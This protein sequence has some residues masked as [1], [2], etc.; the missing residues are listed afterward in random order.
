MFGKKQFLW[1]FIICVTVSLAGYFSGLFIDFTRDAGKYATISRDIFQNGDFINLTVK[2]HPYIQKPPL[3]FWL[4]A[5]GFYVGGVSNFWFKFPVFLV[6]MFGLYSTYRLGKSLYNRNVGFIASVMLFFSVVYSLYSMD[7]HTDTPLQAF[8]AFA[9][10]QL[11]EFIKTKKERHWILGFIGIGLAMLTKGPIGAVV[12]A[13]AV[14]GHLILKKDFRFLFNFRWFLGILIALIVTSPAL[15]GL[16]RHFGWVGIEFFFWKNNFGRITGDYVQTLNYNPMFYV[17]TMVYL[18]FPWI[19]LFFV[20][21]FLDFKSLIKNKFRADEYFTFFGIW[22]FF[23][24]LSFSKGQLPNYIFI[25]M[26]LIAVL[27]S[28]WVDKAITSSDSIYSIFYKCQNVVTVLI[29]VVILTVA[30]YLF[31]TSKWY[32]WLIFSLAFI[33]SLYVFKSAEH[34]TTALLLP[35]IIA[36]ACLH[37]LINT[38]ALPYMFSFQASPKAARYFNE[39]AQKS[40][41]L[42]SYHYGQYELYFY[43][44]SGATQLKNQNELKDAACKSGNWI[45]T[46]EEGLAEIKGLNC[47]PDTVISYKHVNLDQPAKFILPSKRD[48]ALVPFYLVKF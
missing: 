4:G 17:H 34:G 40:D 11:F 23:I 6:A 19:V 9:L 35:S 15:I 46:D 14:A 32:L 8:V 20:S 22:V 31:P 13:F 12:P 7:I 45:F 27:T 26:P 28:K 25:L 39:N 10:W 37:L 33:I 48:K 36:F 21:S 29:W 43:S 47:S 24:I 41:S 18:F 42:Y 5:L 1:I 3:L 44:H 16:F 30:L 38:H 2:G